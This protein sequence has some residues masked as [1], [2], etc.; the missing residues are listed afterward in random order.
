VKF[1]FNVKEE[2]PL[3]LDFSAYI[4]TEPLQYLNRSALALDVLQSLPLG[5]IFAFQGMTLGVTGIHIDL[6]EHQEECYPVDLASA[7]TPHSMV[8]PLN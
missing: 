8:L 6:E 7:S 3:L 4:G 2:I 5:S 1:S